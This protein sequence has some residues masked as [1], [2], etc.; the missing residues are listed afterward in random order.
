MRLTTPGQAEEQIEFTPNSSSKGRF[1]ARLSGLAAGKYRAVLVDDNVNGVPRAVEFEI[2]SPPGELAHTEM[3][4][5]GLIEAA[6]RTRGEIIPLSDS[7][8]LLDRLPTGRPVPIDTLPPYELW[9]RWPLLL[10]ITVCLS[11]EWILRKRRSML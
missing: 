3:N 10:G 2:R 8:N 6:Q 1:T 4:R 9:N 5:S 11:L 7:D